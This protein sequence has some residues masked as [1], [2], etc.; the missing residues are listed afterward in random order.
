MKVVKWDERLLR[1]AVKSQF[2]WDIQNPND[3]ASVL[4]VLPDQCEIRAWDQMISR[5]LSQPSTLVFCL[6]AAVLP[7][8]SRHEAESQSFYYSKIKKNFVQPCNEKKRLSAAFFAET[9]NNEFPVL[10][11]KMC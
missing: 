5:G 11:Y 6:Q 8:V 1:E 10:A 4:T 9:C 7:S 2:F 3:L